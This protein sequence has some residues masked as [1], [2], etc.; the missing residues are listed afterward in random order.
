MKRTLLLYGRPYCHL[1]H[2]MEQALERLQENE[3]FS[4]QS[5]DLDS[6]S[7]LE[8]EYSELIPVLVADGQ[9][10]CHFHLD[11]DA[12]RTWLDST[13]QFSSRG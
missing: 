4:F 12:L 3:D 11:E 1:C 9:I 6:V 13:T 7:E 10:L 5:I 8:D 2:D